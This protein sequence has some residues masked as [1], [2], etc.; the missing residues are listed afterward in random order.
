MEPVLAHCCSAESGCVYRWAESSQ[1]KNVD[2]HKVCSVCGG[3]IAS[4]LIQL[5][6]IC[7]T[8]RCA[9]RRPSDKWHEHRSTPERRGKPDCTVVLRTPLQHSLRCL[10]DLSFKLP[11]CASLTAA[12][13]SRWEFSCTSLL[14]RN[15]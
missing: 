7:H 14:V 6:T 11:L 9:L 15:G 2:L 5:C 3:S 12:A 1:L 8:D 10:C 4:L 13:H